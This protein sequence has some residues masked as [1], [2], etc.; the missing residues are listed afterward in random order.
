MAWAARPHGSWG[1]AEADD[2]GRRWKEAHLG[3]R[4]W[5]RASG[6]RGSFRTRGKNNATTVWGL[7]LSPPGMG[8]GGGIWVPA[9]IWA[10]SR[11]L[12]E[13]DFRPEHPYLTMGV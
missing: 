13:H 12:L 10:R 6:H 11:G 2:R 3:H 7:K 4:R 1:T 5:A 8:A 9:E